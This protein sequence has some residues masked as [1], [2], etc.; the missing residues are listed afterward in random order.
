MGVERTVRW[1]WEDLVNEAVKID[2][3]SKMI[4]ERIRV[5]TSVAETLIASTQ[6]IFGVWQVIQ[7]QLTIGQLIAF[8]M[9]V[10]NVISPF[11]RLIALWNDFQ[12]IRIAIE[13]TDDVINA[14]PEEDPS[15]SNLAVLPPIKG[16]IRFENVTFRYNLESEINTDRKA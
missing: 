7:N 5:A 2:F 1:R 15:N 16:H 3:S 8:N 11:Q 14:R 10:G 9:L 13:R 12:E 4:R 6:L